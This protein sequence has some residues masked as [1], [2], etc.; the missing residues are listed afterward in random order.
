[1]DVKSAVGSPGLCLLFQPKLSP[2]ARPRTASGDPLKVETCI[3]GEPPPLLLLSASP[4]LL[5]SP[6]AAPPAAS[7]VEDI[8]EMIL[9]LRRQVENLFSVKF[10][11]SA[12]GFHQMLDYRLNNPATPSRSAAKK[13]HHPEGQSSST[14]GFKLASIQRS[15]ML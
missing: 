6:L 7:L 13:T 11:T 5:L 14:F 10:G 1:M 2:P 4:P 15:L 12:L 3:P 9:Q 8:G